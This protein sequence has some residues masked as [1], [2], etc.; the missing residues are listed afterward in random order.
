LVPDV[1]KIRQAILIS[2]YMEGWWQ[3]ILQVSWAVFGAALLWQFYYLL[4]YWAVVLWSRDPWSR[5]GS[6]VL[7]V[8]GQGSAHGETKPVSLVIAARN[9]EEQLRRNIPLWMA[10]DHP[11][12]EVIVVNDCSWDQTPAVLREFA[13][14]YPRLRIVTVEEQDKYPT[15]KKF[16]LT[17]GIKAAQHSF[18]VFTDAD[19]R[20][21]HESWLS[22]LQHRYR[23]ETELVIGHV[24][25]ETRGGLLG[26]LQQADH[27]FTSLQCYGHAILGQ[28]FM[29]RGGNLS[30]LR[31][32]FFYH[33]GFSVHL[34]HI[35]GDDGLFVNQAATRTNT[36]LSLHPESWTITR[37]PE[38][39]SAW[40]AQ[41]R[42]HLSSSHYLKWHIK[43]RTAVYGSTLWILMLWPLVALKH[44]LWYSLPVASYFL[45]R[46]ILLGW[47]SVRF[48]V[49][50][51]IPL[52]PLL[53]P[54]HLM[55]RTFW[56]FLSGTGKG[57]W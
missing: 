36:G 53:D 3:E 45:V 38:R 55:L 47:A 9:E 32:L 41:K 17:L 12:Y 11:D 20:P 29:G 42:R 40:F 54:V 31:N 18:L 34:K 24:R 49:G 19:C 56:L 14:I 2:H 7:L 22:H 4:R 1:G 28:A 46:W 5:A 6:T 44:P 51:M 15:G 30:Y 13:E 8:P 43:L 57:R 25:L 26:W 27:L 37:A 50:W 35:S 39:W 21:A 23:P 48:K 52:W 16:A 10:Q 33:K